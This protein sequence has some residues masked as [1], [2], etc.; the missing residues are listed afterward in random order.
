MDTAITVK[1]A[2]K[3]GRELRQALPFL[4][5]YVQPPESGRPREQWD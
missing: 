5:G 1:M 2:I 3:H 4:H